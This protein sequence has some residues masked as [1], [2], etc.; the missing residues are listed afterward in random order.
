MHMDESRG[1]TRKYFNCVRAIYGKRGFLQ[2]LENILALLNI[3]DRS[4]INFYFTIK[5]HILDHCDRV[6][7]GQT[8]AEEEKRQGPKP[9]HLTSTE[10]WMEQESS[11]FNHIRQRKMSGNE[12][13]I[14]PRGVDGSVDH[15]QAPGEF[16]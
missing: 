4:Y 14:T 6:S 10:V 12:K 3:K 15:L 8:G 13:A 11:M 5:D 9:N 16:T 1:N 7:R 2:F